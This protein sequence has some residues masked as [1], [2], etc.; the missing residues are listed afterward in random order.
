L[1]EA[2]ELSLPLTPTGTSAGNK[3]TF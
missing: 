2:F 1:M 3:A